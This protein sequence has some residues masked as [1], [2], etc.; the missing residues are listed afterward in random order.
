ML[1]TGNNSKSS[2]S[3]AASGNTSSTAASAEV[4]NNSVAS[5]NASASSTS[6]SSHSSS[7]PTP[8]PQL[9]KVTAFEFMQAWNGL[10]GTTDIEQYVNVLDQIQPADI[11]KGMSPTLC[12]V[13]CTWNFS[14]CILSHTSAQYVLYK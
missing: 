1:Y 5:V 6:F 4:D 7:A 9:S 8:P 2:G 13:S 10:K 14:V 12:C 3:A 11:T